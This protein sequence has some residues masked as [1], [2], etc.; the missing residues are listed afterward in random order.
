MVTR[1][2]PK[3]SHSSFSDG[4]LSPGRN[5]PDRMNSRRMV[6]R[7]SD[8]S[9]RRA[10]MREMSLLT[11]GFVPA[12]IWAL[13]VRAGVNL[14]AVHNYLESKTSRLPGDWYR[15]SCQTS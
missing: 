15:A 1:E 13:P 5:F 10:L 3:I 2:A 14:K 6:S 9:G 8:C 12:D 11:G 7:I 4:I